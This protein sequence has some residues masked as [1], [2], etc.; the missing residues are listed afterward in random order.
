MLY[1][2]LLTNENDDMRERHD[3]DAQSLYWNKG[4]HLGV[5]AVMKSTMTSFLTLGLRL[6]LKTIISIILSFPWAM[7]QII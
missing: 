1:S 5:L 6:P 7:V 2:F 3:K 4:A